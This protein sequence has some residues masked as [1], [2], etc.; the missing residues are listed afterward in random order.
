MKG[1][2]HAALLY[3]GPAAALS[4]Q[5]GAWA[6][7]YIKLEP[8]TIHISVPGERANQRDLRAHRTGEV[9]AQLLDGLRVT[10]P[11]RTLRDLAWVAS[12]A[13]LRR[14][15]AE[16]DHAGELVPAA[17]A[18]EL[19]RGRRGSTALRRALGEHLPELARTLSILEERFLA[20]LDRAGLPLPEVNAFVDGL[21]VDC[22]WRGA[23]LVVE[24]DGH[25]THD[26]TAAIESDRRREMKLR[27]AG[28]RVL[29]YTWQ[30]VTREDELVVAEL[31]FELRG[32]A[33]TG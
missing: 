28:Y 7:R 4:H 8:R 15:L 24:L 22:V 1:R 21:M 6:R 18:A 31:R 25:E 16:A 26:R 33:I 30:Q 19:G 3:G 5:T 10:P 32:I 20:L 2:L 27:R 23:R 12:Y 14:A 17:V 11:A 13:D 9:R 29:R